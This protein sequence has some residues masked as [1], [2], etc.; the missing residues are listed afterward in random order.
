MK[1]EWVEL[2]EIVTAEISDRVPMKLPDH[3]SVEALLPLF[4]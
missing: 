2:R 4:N 1:P 3:V